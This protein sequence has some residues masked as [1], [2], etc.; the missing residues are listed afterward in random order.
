MVSQK[1]EFVS[2]DITFYSRGLRP[3]QSFDRA[4]QK[5][6]DEDSNIVRVYGTLESVIDPKTKAKYIKLNFPD[7]IIK[8]FQS[9]ELVMKPNTPIIVDKET[10]IKMVNK[11]KRRLKNSTRVWR[12]RN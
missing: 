7:D 5:T 12:K 10:K 9:G 11:E 1:V 4:R 2:T 8:M 3:T 6:R